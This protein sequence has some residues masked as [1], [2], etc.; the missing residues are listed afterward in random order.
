MT[1]AF[2]STLVARKIGQPLS[3]NSTNIFSAVRSHFPRGLSSLIEY[4]FFSEPGPMNVHCPFPNLFAYRVT[5]L[6][7]DRHSFS[8][9]LDPQ[10]ISLNIVINIILL[11]K[12]SGVSPNLNSKHLTSSLSC[13]VLSPVNVFHSKSIGSPSILSKFLYSGDDLSHPNLCSHASFDWV[14]S[15]M[16]PRHN[17]EYDKT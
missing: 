7:F 17:T 5:R 6:A 4:H 12:F 9:S 14:F 3:A 1:F 13:N 16:L 8:L 10:D 2:E 11:V 15:C